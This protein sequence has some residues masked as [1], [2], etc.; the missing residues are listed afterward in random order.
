MKTW[1]LGAIAL[2]AA[3]AAACGEGVTE[4]PEAPAPGSDVELQVA[5]D[6]AL[7]GATMSEAETSTDPLPEEVRA[8]L[9]T[10]RAIFA[11][12]RDA[13][14][15]GKPEQA[16]ELARQGRRC[17]AEAILMARGEAGIAHLFERVAEL[18]ER[19]VD[20]SDEFDRAGEL[21]SRI[22][23]LLREAKAA[24]DEGDLVTAGERLLF[25]LQIAD[26]FRVRHPDNRATPEAAR[27]YVARARAALALAERCIGDGPTESQIVLLRRAAGLTRAAQ[28]AAEAGLNARAVHLAARAEGVAL[29]AV[30]D[31]EPSEVEVG[32]IVEKTQALLREAAERDLGPEQQKLLQLSVRL[33]ERGL[34]ELRAGNLRGI[35]LV[36]KAG[37]SAVLLLS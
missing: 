13:F 29:I 3:G 19:L 32:Q 28:E 10:C 12:A 6:P 8:K 30:F 16:R 17:V 5:A 33:F 31:G 2:L 27:F 21:A 18:L 9:E 22:G 26:H 15:A 37:V 34:S 14:H 23:G 36:W 25:A 1:K 20:A 35:A 11:E 7:A 24:A 4:A